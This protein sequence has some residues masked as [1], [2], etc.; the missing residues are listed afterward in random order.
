MGVNGH[1]EVNGY[2]YLT[3]PRA[4][5]LARNTE[6]GVDPN[7]KSYLEKALIEVWARLQAQPDSYVLSRDE[8]ALFNYYRRRF[9]GSE[10]AQRA[11][12]RFWDHYHGHTG[13]IRAY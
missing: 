8:F 6:G 12:Q 10:V 13:T 4:L 7:I 11:I 1:A 3:I 9:E 5:E 2:G